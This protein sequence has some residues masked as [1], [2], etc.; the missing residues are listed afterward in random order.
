MLGL[1]VKEPRDSR[2]GRVGG[3]SLSCETPPYLGALGDAGESGTI[4]S[5]GGPA[6]GL[7]IAPAACD[8]VLGAATNLM[9]LCDDFQFPAILLLGDAERALVRERPTLLR[10]FVELSSVLQAARRSQSVIVLEAENQIPARV[11]CFFLNEISMGSSPGRSV[12]CSASLSVATRFWTFSSD[13]LIA[14][15]AAVEVINLRWFKS[16]RFASALAPLPCTS[17]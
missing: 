16:R 5:A 6:T 7:P 11:T 4:N 13:F 12:G 14:L 3:G 15:V 8:L 9:L 17:T 10:R 2:N 1:L